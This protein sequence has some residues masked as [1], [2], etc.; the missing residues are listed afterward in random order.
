[1]LNAIAENLINMIWNEIVGSKKHLKIFLNLA[2]EIFTII[3]LG[4]FSQ[5]SG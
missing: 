2:S 5:K 1:M 3:F 4:I